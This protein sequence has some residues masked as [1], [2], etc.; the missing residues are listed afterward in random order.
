MSPYFV[1]ILALPLLPL[2]VGAPFL[3]YLMKKRGK[4][5]NALCA[6]F[7]GSV[8]RWG[9]IIVLLFVLAVIGDT[10]INNNPQG[11]LMLLFSGVPFAVGGFVGLA[12]WFKKSNAT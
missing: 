1:L 12:L 5:F 2:V 11:P 8:F 4:S 10:I 3:V 7:L 9:F 6:P